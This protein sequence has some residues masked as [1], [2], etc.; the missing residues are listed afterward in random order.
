[1]QNM[2]DLF[3][4]RTVKNFRQID[5]KNQWEAGEFLEDIT[6]NMPIGDSQPDNYDLREVSKQ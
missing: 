2:V 1:M 3:C 6:P 5:C 4:K